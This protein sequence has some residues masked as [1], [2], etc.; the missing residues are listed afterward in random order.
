MNNAVTRSCAWISLACLTY[1]VAAP[2][3]TIETIAGGEIIIDSPALETSDAPF[4]TD[5]GPDGRI[6]IQDDSNGF[7]VRYDP[8][9]GTVTALPGT[10][11]VPAFR[12]IGGIRGFVWDPQGRFHFANATGVVRYDLT[13]GVGVGV[14]SQLALGTSVG[15]PA[16]DAAGNLYVPDGNGDV[17]R[18]VRPNGQVQVFAG[19]IGGGFS[20]DGGL[21]TAARIDN[22]TAVAVDVAGNV[23]IADSANNRI[24]KVA[25]GTG[26]ITTVAGTGSSANSADGLLAVQT[27]FA[28][29]SALAF[30]GAGNLFVAE[31]NF[32]RV[33][34]IGGGNGFVTTVAGNGTPG[35]SGDGGLG[36]L[37]QVNVG[38]GFT[39]DAAGNVY[40]ADWFNARLRR[41]DAATG[42]IQTVLGNGKR[43]FCGDNRPA[44][45]AC[46]WGPN[47]LALDPAEN[48]YIGD[49]I[50]ERIRR[51]TAA[52]GIINTIAGVDETAPHSGDGGPAV[53]ANFGDMPRGIARDAAGN[54]YIAGAFS[55]RVRRITPAGIITTIAGTGVAGFSGDGGL[56]TA[57]QLREPSDVAIDRTGNIYISD[58]GNHRVR[59]IDTSGVI[60]TFAGTGN[61][62]GV[63]DSNGTPLGMSLNLPGA[64]AIDQLGDLLIMDRGHYRLR[65]IWLSTGREAI[66]AG[67]GSAT[68]SGV[69]GDYAGGIG[70][71]P[72]D[73]IAVHRSGEIYFAGPNRIR[74]MDQWGLIYDVAGGTFGGPLTSQTVSGPT[75]MEFD[76]SGR[77]I[78]SEMNAGLV[79][80]MSGLAQPV[81]DLTPPGLSVSYVGGVLGN[82]GWYRSDVLVRFV[83]NEPDSMAYAWDN[84]ATINNVTADTTGRTFTCTLSSFGGTTTRTATVKRDVTPPV[85]TFG[86]PT[87]APDE[88]G[89]YSGDV[90]IPFTV[91]DA[92]SGVQ[93]AT[94]GPLLITGTGTGLTGSV[95]ATDRAGNTITVSSPPVNITR[96]QPTV[97]HTVTG[98][99]GNEGWYRGNVQITWSIDTA[100]S[101]I[102]SQSGCEAATVNTDTAGTTFTCTVTTALGTATDSV[103]VKRDAT[104]PSLTFGTYSPAP[105]EHDW[106]SGDVSVP[107]TVTDAYS[108]VLSSNK[109]NPVII[110][111]YGTSWQTVTVTDVAGNSQT[112][113][114]QIVRIDRTPPNMYST[115]TGTEGAN[116]WYR[117]N[118]HLVWSAW[119]SE[120]FSTL[121]GCE[122]QDVVADTAGTTFTCTATSAGGT[123][124]RSVTIKRDATPPTLTFGAASPAADANGWR[125]GPV[126]VSF[127]A[128]DALSGLASTSK[129]SPLSITT[130]GAGVTA[131]V[132]ATDQAGNSATFT[133]PAYDIDASPPVV[134]PFVSGTTG[135]NGW[136]KSDVHVS[137]GVTDPD[138]AILTRDG[139]DDATVS[140]DT[141]GITFACTATSAGGTTSK[142]VTIRRDATPPTLTWGA[143]SP[144]PNAVG[145]NT[146]DVS[147]AF[148][149]DDVMSGVAGTS[150]ASPAVVPFDGPNVSTQITVWDDAGNSVTLSTPPVSIDRS[151]PVVNYV[152][153]GTPGSNGWYT[154]DV[155]VT[156]QVVKA[157]ENILAQTGCVNT[158][159][160]ADTA[161]TTF[162]CSVTSGAGTTSQSVTIKRDATPPTLSW[163]A[164]SPLPNANGWNKTNVTVPFTRADATSGVASTSATSPL[165]LSV[166]GASVTGQVTVTDNA[167]NSHTF[168]T[169]PRNIDKTAPVVSIT[170][171]ANGAS[172][173][174]YQDVVADFACT[175]TSLLSCTGPNADGD[176]V[177]TR[178]SGPRT[179]KVTAK[180]QV[181]YTTSVTSSFE[182]ANSFNWEGFLPSVAP[183]PSPNLVAKGSLVP[184][185]WRLPDGHGGFVTN[186]ASFS[187][188]T[189]QSYSCSGTVVPLNDPA[190]GPAG[191]SFDPATSVFT[192]NWQT[193]ASW[194]GCRKLVIKLKDG[195]LHELV[196]KFQ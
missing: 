35:F 15:H 59:R 115:I 140:A 149:T 146:T 120:S 187:S 139:C 74:K 116:G 93:S 43:H 111:G 45:G 50:N 51:V 157:P 82:N 85:V 92:T 63:L 124:T 176:F 133:T 16:F 19:G 95:T 193:G 44:V 54:L 53:S 62:D 57:A 89:W 153:T 86:I 38:N 165:A 100:G 143:P 68:A 147:F 81:G 188:A 173:G 161:G 135:T 79:R 127:E 137:F 49:S 168:V 195:N 75:E 6:Y 174:F 104:A 169:D 189:V 151:V 185:R 138:S 7:I 83:T 55:N 118:V 70:L 8:A 182:V 134:T 105:D 196:F 21:A 128:S 192:Y 130:A 121:T 125:T 101:S 11:G 160:T 22:P 167:G 23:F 41:V 69:N 144:A 163:G 194:T 164:F 99:L 170:A 178:T 114:T 67:N 52:T 42:M 90:T 46:L 28:S 61:P 191:I 145:W 155:Q 4:R 171:P 31:P 91:T 142:S 156:W 3:Q 20:G 1:T 122:T 132:T 48:L 78:F 33:R 129:P 96:T 110:T 29:P 106:Y 24:R 84:C 123:T 25:A 136:Y 58:T 32:G 65:K 27:N 103:T 76:G 56:A 5:V 13:T 60:T 108:G 150:H 10:A 37:A 64:L 177:N 73:G 179:F 131:Q 112:Y 113:Q 36:Y 80:R 141:A 47:G 94:P 40:V 30:D 119:E 34:R 14:A 109:P 180:D 2:A 107:Y 162:G 98:Y 175:D 97:R 87:P 172:Y 26:V 17:V 66:F 88:N 117:G 12:V 181:A 158:S 39:V 102:E 9:A 184:I 71:G 159:V 126:Q 186:T 18:V 190:T 152:V 77:L 183:L 148:T 154:D 72:I 166:E